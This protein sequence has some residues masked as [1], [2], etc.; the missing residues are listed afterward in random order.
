[1]ESFRWLLLGA[2]VL[3]LGGIYALYL[4]ERRYP[5][6]FGKADNKRAAKQSD[7]ADEIIYIHLQSRDGLINGADLFRAME[8]SGLSFG[9]M[10]IFHRLGENGKPL[11]SAANSVK[12]G[13]FELDNLMNIETP[14]IALFL[15]LSRVADPLHALDEMWAAAQTLAREL[16]ADILDKDRKPLSAQKQQNMRDETLEYIRRTALRAR[17]G[18]A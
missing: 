13:G 6:W 1:M 15:R 16:D 3:L 7:A 8:K 2:G 4:L 14:G 12:P 9:E 11:F 17:A 18:R 5:R 10:D